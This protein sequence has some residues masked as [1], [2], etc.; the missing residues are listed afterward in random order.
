M[1]DADNADVLLHSLYPTTA[2]HVLHRCNAYE[3]S[4]RELLAHNPECEGDCNVDRKWQH[5]NRLTCCRRKMR[6]IK[7][8]GPFS[9]RTGGKQRDNS[10]GV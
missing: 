4:L 5:V 1:T 8:Q 10:N 7:R 6:A 3:A 9:R 2:T